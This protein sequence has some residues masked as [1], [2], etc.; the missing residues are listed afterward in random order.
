[1]KLLLK[2]RV[3]LILLGLLVEKEGQSSQQHLILLEM[4]FFAY[5]T[6]YKNKKIYFYI[7]V[8]ELVS[9]FLNIFLEG[10]II[11]FLF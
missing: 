2:Q 11:L 9:E 5:Q 1:M 7:K 3:H 10:V 8:I 6:F 4:L